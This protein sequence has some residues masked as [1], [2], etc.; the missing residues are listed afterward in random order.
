VH[1][2]ALLLRLNR[3]VSDHSVNV[4]LPVAEA[5]RRFLAAVVDELAAGYT[6]HMVTVD[7]LGSPIFE[8]EDMAADLP[9]AFWDAWSRRAAA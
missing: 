3:L 1:E 5:M 9:G 8:R 7:E 2:R 6:L 4:N